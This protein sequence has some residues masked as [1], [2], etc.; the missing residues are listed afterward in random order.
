MNIITDVTNSWIIL[1]FIWGRNGGGNERRG[2]GVLNK[3]SL[4]YY[5]VPCLGATLIVLYISRLNFAITYYATQPNNELMSPMSCCK[6]QNKR[7][8]IEWLGN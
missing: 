1:C 2:I 7:S 8:I 6:T 3:L 4:L 5:I